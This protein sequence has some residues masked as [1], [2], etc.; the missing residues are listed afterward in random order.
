MFAE[1]R[2]QGRFLCS[3]WSKLNV[4][5]IIAKKFPTIYETRISLSCSQEPQIVI[6]P[7][8]PN[9]HAILLH[10]DLF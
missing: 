4:E 10:Y 9:H 5:R 7:S 3:K 2:L 8:K 1:Q 6:L